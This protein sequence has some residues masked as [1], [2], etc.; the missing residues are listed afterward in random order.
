MTFFSSRLGHG[1][2]A[3]SCLYQ[4]INTGLGHANV[5]LNRSG[6][7]F[8]SGAVYREGT[9]RP[10]ERQGNSESGVNDTPRH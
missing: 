3:V 8:F 1:G 4:Y 2:D 5:S 7:R 9:E 6:Q 10:S